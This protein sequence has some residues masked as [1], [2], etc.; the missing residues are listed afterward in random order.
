MSCCMRWRRGVIG[1]SVHH[2]NGM[3]MVW[4]REY[5]RA[6]VHFDAPSLSI[7]PMRKFARTERI[8]CDSPAGRRRL[9]LQST[10]R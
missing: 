6:G 4:L 10:T 1:A 9:W 8:G 7:R 5:E 3:V 2:A